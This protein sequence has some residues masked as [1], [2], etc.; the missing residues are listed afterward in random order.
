MGSHDIS[1]SLKPGSSSDGE[2]FRTPR[3]TLPPGRGNWPTCLGL[4]T[5]ESSE[6]P[7]GDLPNASWPRLW[8][9]TYP[10]SLLDPSAPGRGA[11]RTDRTHGT[12][13]R[14]KPSDWIGLRLEN[15]DLNGDHP[16]CRTVSCAGR[17]RSQDVDCA[18]TIIRPDRGFCWKEYGRSGTD[19]GEGGAGRRN[20]LERRRL[21]GGHKPAS[22]KSSHPHL[23]GREQGFTAL[24]DVRGAGK[25]GRSDGRAEHDGTSP[26]PVPS[27][28]KSDLAMFR[29]TGHLL[30]SLKR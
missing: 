12:M 27:A 25:V 16:R 23:K 5:P 30:Y 13:D 18:R 21:G 9:G 14:F 19:A 3:S 24:P 8:Y 11:Q 15:W 2:S 29:S 1:R 20:S 4:V 7:S 6:T 10:P 28:G 17:L 26:S 22:Q